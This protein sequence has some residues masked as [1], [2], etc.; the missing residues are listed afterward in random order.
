MSA[1]G[2]EAVRLVMTQVLLSGDGQKMDPLVSLYYY[3]PV[4]AFMNF[5]LVWFTEMP[6]FNMEDFV[7][8]GPT[9]LI[10]NASVAFLLNLAS[11]FLVG[12]LYSKEGVSFTDLCS[13]RKDKQLGANPDRNFQ[14]HPTCCGRSISLGFTN[15]PPSTLRL[16]FGP[17]GP[18]FLLCAA[19]NRTRVC[20]TDEEGACY[21]FAILAIG[22]SDLRFPGDFE[23]CST[24][25][26][27]D[28]PKFGNC[29][30]S[31]VFET[32]ITR[33]M[34]MDGNVRRLVYRHL[35]KRS[36]HLGKDFCHDSGSHNSKAS[37]QSFLL[38]GAR[39][40]VFDSRRLEI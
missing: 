40:E 5:L 2:F 3:A 30:L 24:R 7:R 9:I 10:I 15:N 14:I 37:L 32:D 21:D 22:P 20:G 31:G 34:D 4:C 13:D 17:S 26:T 16:Q 33:G 38:S 36:H 11:L 27:P 19:R 12:A 39:S 28:I 25:W 1:I 18:F 35:T 6:T 8:V 29:M 23:R